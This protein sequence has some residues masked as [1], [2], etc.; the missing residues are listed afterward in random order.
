[1]AYNTL[2]LLAVASNSPW[3]TTRAAGGQFTNFPV[4]I[5][6]VYAIQALL[7]VLLAVG[8]SRIKPRVA[9]VLAGLFSLS[10]LVQ[11]L[12]QSVDERWNAIPAAI[13]AVTFAVVAAKASAPQVPSAG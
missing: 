3:A 13:L 11:L 4:W 2:I 5:R 10:T 9:V 1:M 6:I 7:M 12:S 8:L